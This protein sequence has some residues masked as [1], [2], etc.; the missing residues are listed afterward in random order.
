MVENEKDFVVG[1]FAARLKM[2]MN[3]LKHKNIKDFAEK[4]GVNYRTIQTYLSGVA[5]PTATTLYR[6]SE[7]FDVS[8]D[9]LV[10]GEGK[11]FLNNNESNSMLPGVF[12]ERL[13]KDLDGVSYTKLEELSFFSKIPNVLKGIDTL[14]RIE[15]IQLAKTLEQPIEEY[16]SLANFFPKIFDVALRDKKMSGLLRSTETF[17]AEEV[18]KILDTLGLILE[19]YVLKKEKERNSGL[20]NKD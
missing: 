16:L 13:R 3:L 9:W 20:E 1:D 7:A 12:I 10:K 18:D 14:N 8:L 19:G 17:T 4:S 11:I 15:V 6:I 2:L 5:S